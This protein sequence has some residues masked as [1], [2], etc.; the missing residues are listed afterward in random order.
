M[1]LCAQCISGVR[2]EG[3]PEGQIQTIAGVQVYVATPTIDYPKDKAILFLTDVFG[4]PLSNNKLLADDFARNGFKVYVPDYFDNDALPEDALNPGSNYDFMGWLGKHPAA[5]TLPTIRAL[6]AALKA[7]GITKFAV[8]GFCYGARPGFDLAYTGEIDIVAVSHPSLLKIPED[9]EKYAAESKAPL[10]I[11]SCTIDQQF[12]PE[13]QTQADD[14]LGGGKF[15]P[16]YTRTYWEGCTHGFA[17]RG[18]LSDP[19]VKAG[20]EGAFKATVEFLIKYL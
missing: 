14:I 11:N 8:A 13:A 1:S 3:E 16:G 20:K 6:I 15:A 5:G 18:D 2:H 17:V 7:E 9:L 19:N 12:P 4:L 10:L